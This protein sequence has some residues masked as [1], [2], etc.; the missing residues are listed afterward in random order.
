MSAI[1]RRLRVL[2]APET[3][4]PIISPDEVEALRHSDYVQ[5]SLA[6]D[7]E[8]DDDTAPTL[9][10]WRADLPDPVVVGARLAQA[11]VEVMAGTRPA[12]QVVRHTAPEVYAALCRRA[13]VATR[14]SPGLRRAAVVR[15][16][17]VQEPRDGVVEA[18]AVVVHQDR[19][20]AMAL[21]MAGIDGRWV[22]TVLQVG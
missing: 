8:P 12:P 11:F 9:F 3:R 10:T 15:G 5:D 2:P 14:R 13:A 17:R 1:A 16:V 20:R 22:V 7:F 6:L 19:V 18:C 21:R 4:P